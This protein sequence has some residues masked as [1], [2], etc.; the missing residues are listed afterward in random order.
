LRFEKAFG[1]TGA[2]NIVITKAPSK[3]WTGRSCYA[4]RDDALAFCNHSEGASCKLQPARRLSGLKTNRLAAQRLALRLR[5]NLGTRIYFQE[6]L[7]G[8]RYIYHRHSSLF[9]DF[10]SLRLGMWS[11]IRRHH[12]FGISYWIDRVVPYH[13]L[14]DLCA[15]LAG[16]VLGLPTSQKKILSHLRDHRE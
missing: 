3:P 9:C 8:R 2:V 1:E 12:G 14:F 15:P 6:Q 5:C 11:I 7:Y 10:F 4:W 13:G 16:E